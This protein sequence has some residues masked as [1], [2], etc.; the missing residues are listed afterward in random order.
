MAKKKNSEKIQVQDREITLV[1]RDQQEY[2]CLTDMAESDDI[3]NWLRNK[4][5]VEFLGV[6]ER[7]HNPDF[8]WVEFDLIMRE[9][10]LNRFKLS[11]KQ[12]VTKTGAIG[13]EARAGRYG[14]TYA[15]KDI[16]FEFGAWISPEFKLILIKEFDRLKR[17]EQQRLAQGWDY[18]R[19]LT[20]VNYR[21]HTDT[22]RD[23]ILPKL[24]TQSDKA[25]LVY[26]DEADLLNMAAFG[27]TAR[28]WKEDHPELAKKGNQRDH[29]DILQLS[30][31]ANLESLN[32]ALIEQGMDKETRFEILVKTAIS[33]YRR[34]A[35]QEAYK[36]LETGQGNEV[37]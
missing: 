20:K 25:W 21:L 8:N 35:D 31:L 24:R 23:V 7:L 26:A 12:W 16:A 13:L 34:L 11:A 27:K 30:V 3:K 1:R 33:Q 17:E 28:Q 9:A 37:T 4:N 22:I 29:A 36:Y 10:G 19:F 2:I 18:R 14:G 32:A 5:T 15:H 6:W